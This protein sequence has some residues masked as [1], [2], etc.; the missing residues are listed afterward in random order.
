MERIERSYLYHRLIGALSFGKRQVGGN[1]TKAQI[2]ELCDMVCDEICTESVM[3]VSATLP[4]FKLG[5]LGKFGRDEPWPDW[6]DPHG[7]QRDFSISAPAGEQLDL[8]S[9][10]ATS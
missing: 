1:L 7:I 9:D 8:D 10:A 2:Y 5:G 3:V 4:G 6:C